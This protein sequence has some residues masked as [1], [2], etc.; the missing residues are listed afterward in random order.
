MAEDRTKELRKLR[1]RIRD[2]VG[3]LQKMI[4][5]Y[6]EEVNKDVPEGGGPLDELEG[7]FLDRCRTRFDMPDDEEEDEAWERLE[8]C[9]EVDDHYLPRQFRVG[10]ELEGT[11]SK[12]LERMQGLA[13]A[14]AQ[15]AAQ[16]PDKENTCR[17]YAWKHSDLPC[18]G[19]LQFSCVQGRDG[20]YI[21]WQDQLGRTQA[22]RGDL[23]AVV[24]RDLKKHHAWGS[25]VEITLRDSLAGT[26]RKAQLIIRALEKELRGYEID[27][28]RRGIL[29]E[30]SVRSLMKQMNRRMKEHHED[31]S[32]ILGELKG[33]GITENKAVSYG[34][35]PAAPGSVRPGPVPA[36]CVHLSAPCQQAPAQMAGS[37]MPA[38]A[39]APACVASNGYGQGQGDHAGYDPIDSGLPFS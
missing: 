15:V 7:M 19:S 8:M 20:F 30:D 32:V 23:V 18:D 16:G 2:S 31:R 36:R 28:S 14:Y 33:I 21:R 24:K 1:H 4:S 27:E 17:V 12:I 37:Y 13:S 11:E 22:K 34:L 5:S 35:A 10:R 39:Y 25:G 9:G 26:D 38:Q 3:E 29:L 6:Q